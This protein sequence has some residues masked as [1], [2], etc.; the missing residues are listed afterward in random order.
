MLK[1]RDGQREETYGDQLKR[2]IGF[3]RAEIKEQD[4][5]IT[6]TPKEKASFQCNDSKNTPLTSIPPA[7]NPISTDGKPATKVC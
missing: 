6:E 4:V 1:N 7:Y 3:K 5:V 2:L